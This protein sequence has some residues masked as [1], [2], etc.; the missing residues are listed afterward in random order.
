[1]SSSA[2]GFLSQVSRLDETRWWLLKNLSRPH[3]QPSVVQAPPS[4]LPSFPGVRKN[5]ES[6]K[7]LIVVNRH[8]V[9]ASLPQHWALDEIYTEI[10]LSWNLLDFLWDLTQE[11]R[12][13]CMD[14]SELSINSHTLFICI[15]LR[16]FLKEPLN[17]ISYFFWYQWL[18]G[19]YRDTL[20]NFILQ[21]HVLS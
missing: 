7:P 10:L 9:P 15:S 17:R 6:S 2:P 20:G 16:F 18:W 12:D 1:M 14:G 3:P 21:G 11:L 13:G 8:P 19:S 5:P 4:H